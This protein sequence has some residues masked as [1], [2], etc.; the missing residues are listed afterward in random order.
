MNILEQIGATGRNRPLLA[1]CVT[2]MLAA[3]CDDGSERKSAAPPPPPAVRVAKVAQETIPII[4][5]FPGTVKSVK[6]VEIVPRVSGYIDKR[7]FD[8]GTFLKAGDPLYLI[9]P[10]QFQVRL[11]ARQAQLKKDLATLAYWKTE[12]DRH[13]RQPPLSGRDRFRQRRHSDDAPHAHHP[14][15]DSTGR[16]PTQPGRVR[17]PRS[18]GQRADGAAGR[19]GSR[20]SKWQDEDPPTSRRPD[21]ECDA[22]SEARV[23][24][25]YHRRALSARSIP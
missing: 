12:A 13:G 1:A 14:S 10:R 24:Y 21:G 9:D 17:N 4:M 8:E 15:A 2:A 16:L 18:R 25:L 3:A 22:R 7:Y 23:S 5:E 11:K 6:M 19:P 20:R